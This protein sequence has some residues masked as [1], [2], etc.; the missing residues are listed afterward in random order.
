MIQAFAG[1]AGR[2]GDVNRAVQYLMLQIF[3]K[4]VIINQVNPDFGCYE[5]FYS[6]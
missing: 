3:W 1:V 6:R 2:W 4:I 5:P